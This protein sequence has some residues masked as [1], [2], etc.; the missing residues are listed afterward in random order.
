MT[1]RNPLK[2][3]S[4][5]DLILFEEENFLVI[6]KPPLISTLDDRSSDINILSLVRGYQP[7]AKVCHRLD[8]E[9]SGLLVI[10]KHADFYKYFAGLLEERE[11]TKLYHAVVS[12]IK[13][14]DEF[15]IDRAI[16]VSSSGSRIDDYEGKASVTLVSTIERYRKHT[17][18]AC[19]PFTGRTHQ[20]RVHLSSVGT[21]IIGDHRYGGQD[22]FL[23]S[24]KRNYSPSKGKPEEPLIRRVALH[25][26]GL[27]F[28]LPNGE[29]MRL[30]AP[31]PKDFEVLLKQL[32]KNK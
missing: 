15:E 21:P 28:N 30:R 17:L 14:F 11:V 3:I 29:E 20:I 16:R 27:A 7:D 1:K 8:K 19:M 24:L 13:D 4:F 23:S 5:E 6:N 12:G 32:E 10:A 9:T 26:A 2:G 25:A 18:V 22:I 31:Y